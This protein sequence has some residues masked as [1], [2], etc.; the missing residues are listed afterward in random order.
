MTE[1]HEFTSSKRRDEPI[2]FTLDGKLY[3]FRPPKRAGI[4]LAL[5]YGGDQVAYLQSRFEWLE[6]GLNA[7]DWAGLDDAARR[8]AWDLNGQDPAETATPTHAP[9]DWRGPQAVEIERRLRD[10]T[11]ELDSDVLEKII[12]TLV[13]DVAGRPTT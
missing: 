5:Y 6:K 2:D 7:S 11:D 1:P 13:Q 4:A 3:G 10:D 8:Q 12:D 9:E